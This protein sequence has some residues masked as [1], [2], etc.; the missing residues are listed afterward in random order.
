[1]RKTLTCLFWLGL[2]LQNSG[3]SQSK[4]S[5][6]GLV[7]DRAGNLVPFA[8]LYTKLTDSS[9]IT[10]F[11]SSNDQGYFAF[12]APDQPNFLVF[13]SAIGYEIQKINVRNNSQKT[14]EIN[15]TLAPKD[16]ILNEVVVRGS[17]KVIQTKDTVS[18]KADQYRDSTERNLE[19]L[20]AKIPGLDVDKNTG[21]ISVQGQPIKKILVDGDDLTGRNYQ[22]L[23]KNMGADVVDKI[24]VID[25]F[26][27]NKL[28]KGLKRTDDKVLNITLKEN[29]KKLLFG[30]VSGGF[31]NDKRTNNSLNLFGFYKKLKTIT[32]GNYNNTGHAS[33]AGR[34]S[35]I[36]FKEDTESDN[37]RSLLKSTNA[38]LID[39]GRMPSVA[40][41]SQTSR[42]NNASLGSTHFVIRPKETVYVK[43][44]LTFS[45][46]NAKS[47]VDNNFVYLLKDSV[48]TLSEQNTITQ[49]PTILE[50][51][52]EA[53]FDLSEKS[54]LRYKSDFRKSMF[55]NHSATIANQNFINNTQKSNVLAFANTL[56]F[57][58][59]ISD[60]HALTFNL[61]TIQDRN[62]QSLQLT[63]SLV[64]SASFLPEPFDALY[65][66][67]AKP[68][69][70]YAAAAQWLLAKN[71]LKLSS[72][73]GVVAK[74]ESLGS[75]LHSA[76]QNNSYASSDSLQNDLDLQQKNYYTGLNL[77]E[78]WFGFEVFADISG[79]FYHTAISGRANESS[80]YALPVV[81]L[82][83]SLKE[84]HHFFS[85]YAYN[86]ALPQ[87]VDLSEGFVLTDYR[88]I[89]RGSAL[90][91]QQYS[92][93][94]IFNYK[95]GNFADEFLWHLN[96]V[97]TTN[98]KGY[99][100][101]FLINSDFNIS[102]KVENNLSN[103]N[104]IV[105]GSI[106]KY[107]PSLHMRL[108]LRPSVGLGSYPNTLNGSDIRQTNSLNPKLDISLRSAYLKWFN[109]HLGS[110]L[111]QSRISTQSK[112]L[113]TNVKNQSV[114]AFADFYMKFRGKISARISNEVFYF[115]P[116][117][118]KAQK[119]YFV[120]ATVSSEI[121]ETK[122]SATL[123]VQNILNTKQFITPYITDFSTQTNSTKLLP[124][125]V[126]LE[127]NYRF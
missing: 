127:L 97:H 56:D 74:N 5:V 55:S 99:R 121:I 123:S 81:G 2:L 119:Y 8:T 112:D 89:S 59:R 35:G 34:M 50:G 102:E 4:I 87:S 43:G 49:K 125:Y 90:Y 53:Q 75:D 109:F 84:K 93:T 116:Q 42:F 122:L 6:K 114:G 91:I 76:F 44:A 100:S 104:T 10:A 3:Y 25:R 113:K 107:M 78:E 47:F 71:T 65:Q 111:S 66:N 126:L 61:T 7:K 40:L 105:S 1:M 103:K 124:R 110:T 101:N 86:F 95:F 15:F 28:L 13:A 16:F 69:Q 33:T 118:A 46:D 41:S 23:S 83:R 37:L 11:G 26:T 38:N 12:E 9:S 29:R 14:L 98:S 19:E 45:H 36:D 70:Y 58:R 57:T 92:H 117:N 63:Q 80:L 17:N 120:N 82:K 24:Q 21:A 72:Y 39:I 85:T 60:Y 18:F 30:N 79:G 51:H 62:R 77:K 68:M 94:A 27:E 22:L 115:K 20:L 52:L 48:F 88:S 32:F 96:I 67:I 73:V 106:E 108:K 31:G 54:L 64:R